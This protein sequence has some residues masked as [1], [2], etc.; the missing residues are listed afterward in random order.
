VSEHLAQGCYASAEHA[1]RF[2]P[3]SPGSESSALTT[4]PTRLTETRTEICLK[5]CLFEIDF[6]CSICVG[7]GAIMAS[8][9]NFGNF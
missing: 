4:M 2:E 3:G 8:M 1:P 7:F 6:S 5:F 9:Q